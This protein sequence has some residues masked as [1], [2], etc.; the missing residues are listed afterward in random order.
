MAIRF[1]CRE[2]RQ[3][4]S[5]ASRKAGTVIECPKCAAVQVVP[6]EETAEAALEPLFS[7][8]SPA[9]TGLDLA[10]ESQ[11]LV[12]FDRPGEMTAF[13]PPLPIP[14]AASD[15]APAPAPAMDMGSPLPSDW[16]LFRRHTIYV[17]GILFVLVAL[18]SLGLGVAIGRVSTYL[19]PVHGGV[20]ASGD[21]P[22]QVLVEGRLSYDPGDGKLAGD[23]DSVLLFV[24]ANQKP[25]EVIPIRGLRP[26]D[27]PPAA[28]H[29][30]LRRV[31][32]LGGVYAR[33]D[34][35][36]V[37]HAVLPHGGKYYLLLISRHVNRPADAFIDEVDREQIGKYF[38]RAEDLIGRSRYRWTLETF[39]SG[40]PAVSHNFGRE[41]EA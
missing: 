4:L 25:A 29:R 22:G 18:V 30:G 14:V 12:V 16:I 39:R 13:G 15:P 10:D 5:I 36:G 31:E 26:Q 21:E 11:G 24:P 20:L 40:G 28:S 32:E 6:D 1:L 23:Q 34:A 2:C 41:G 8:Q 27:P 19:G 9:E 37:F 17:Q 3:L 35:T 7:R 33:V 38:S